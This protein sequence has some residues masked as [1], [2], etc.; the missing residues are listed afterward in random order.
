MKHCTLLLAIG[1]LLPVSI[2]A[3]ESSLVI[4]NTDLAL[5]RKVMDMDLSKGTQRVTFSEV[6]DRID[7]T[8]V[9]LESP[10]GGVKLIEQSFQFAL[11]SSQR[12]LQETIGKPLTI[13]V[14]GGDIIQGTLLSSGGDIVLRES[15]GRINVLRADS[16][17]RFEFPELPAGMVS[18]PVLVWKLDSAR[19][20]KNRVIVSYLTSGLTWH[21]EYS[22]VVNAAQTELE[23]SSLVSL[24]NS[25]GESF[26]DSQLKLVAGDIH[27][28]A[29]PRPLPR[30]AA[31]EAMMAAPA[32][33]QAG[34]FQ[35]RGVSEYHLY[36]L[37]GKTTVTNAEI[38]QISLFPPI[39]TAVQRKF[40]FDASRDPASVSVNIEFVNTEKDGL[41]M[42]LPGG[43]VRAYRLDTDNSPVLVGEDVMAHTPKN[44]R[45]RL[46]LGNAFDLKAERKVMDNRTISAR[47]NEQEVEVILRNQKS[48][49][50][51]I[52]VVESLHGDWEIVK[53]SQDFVRKDANTIEF[54][55]NVPAG[56]QSAV[57]YTVRN[58]F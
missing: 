35:E 12:I 53:K 42:P 39:K 50:A 46:N 54:I 37:Q 43:K 33:D 27:R 41:G 20:G 19:A 2:R 57:L 13:R 5:V 6:S 15:G 36:E 3:Q 51:T 32:A 14:K 31:K 8:S 38:K 47:I 49:P 34:G 26:P 58:K 7:P 45:V 11:V 17:E 29:S 44:E 25:S 21:A 28:A 55:V 48:Q 4:Y 30:F 1:L 24:E 9:R 23:L 56:G 52:T 22:A 40:V 16:I 18:R 10:D